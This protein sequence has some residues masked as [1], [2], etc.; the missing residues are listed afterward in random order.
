M[1]F[2]S[3]DGFFHGDIVE[4]S[5]QTTLVQWARV[6]MCLLPS[7]SSSGECGVLPNVPP[8]T[9]HLSPDSQLWHGASLPQATLWLLP[10]SCLHRSSKETVQFSQSHLRGSKS[11]WATE[12]GKAAKQW[13]MGWTG[14]VQCN[15]F[16][17]IC[18]D[19]RCEI[20]SWYQ[21]DVQPK[22]AKTQF[23]RRVV[24]FWQNLCDMC[25]NWFSVVWVAQFD[26]FYNSNSSPIRWLQYF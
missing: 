9:L 3:R 5:L 17:S 2:M 21:G 22:L 23:L 26:S 15:P 1:K 10:A 11:S 6:L 16:G 24:D 20:H 18:Y 14:I 19:I 25:Q 7:F 12:S 13:D 4:M 8:P